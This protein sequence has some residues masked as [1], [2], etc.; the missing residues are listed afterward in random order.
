MPTLET[1]PTRTARA[2]FGAQ[3]VLGAG[4]WIAVF[5]SDRARRWTLGAWSP[6]L[7][8]GPDLVLFVGA[9]AWAAL[10]AER[11]AATV[12]AAWTATVAAVLTGYALVERAA[13]WGVVA[14][15]IA[16]VG[17]LAA[18]ATLRV[19]H[20]PHDR[21]FVGPFSFRVA[22]AATRRAHVRRSLRQ[23]VTF[24]IAF[25]VLV[26]AILTA[27][28]DRLQIRW[29]ALQAPSAKV[30]SV[31]ALAT[32]S[33]FAVWACLSMARDG[34]GTPLPA[35]TARRLVVSGPYRYVRNPMALA[36]GIQTGSV[37]LLLGSWTVVAIAV[38]GAV[39]WNQLI[40][41]AEERD[42]EARLGLP[43][44][45]YRDAVRCWIPTRPAPDRPD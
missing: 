31:V 11:T 39:A 13:G 25:F 21:L 4:W 43:Y 17:S 27:A 28:E 14:M 26:P 45:A 7:L 23:L 36:G 24:W 10:R 1:G 33:P 37:G 44:A 40:R 22:A 29:A 16:A 9:S 6:G 30:V 12:A 2:W 15:A 32:V 3:A 38:A 5:A 34:E 8:V 35:A 19:G 42:L 18:A 20:L 41:P